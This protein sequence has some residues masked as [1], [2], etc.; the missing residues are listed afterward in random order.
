MGIMSK[1]VYLIGSLR[2]AEI[3]LIANTLRKE[4]FEV[5]DDWISPGPTTDDDWRD[6]EKTRGRTY[7]DALKGFHARHVFAFDKF[8][9][10]RSDIAILV[11]PA[12]RSAHLELGWMLGKGKKGYILLDSPDRWD[13]MMCFADGISTKLEEIVG[14][15]K[16]QPVTHQP[17]WNP[18]TFETLVKPNE[19]HPSPLVP[20]Y[21]GYEEPC[22]TCGRKLHDEG[23]DHA[24]CR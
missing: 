19:P 18:V 10:E 13:I 21:N 4:G 20:K 14:M 8:H 9:L 7:V 22:W 3:P 17:V 2:N 6:Y 24:T 1:R 23:I 5:F 11:L 15:I 16:G 12:G